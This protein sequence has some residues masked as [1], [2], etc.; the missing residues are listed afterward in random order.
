M[1]NSHDNSPET[2]R[3]TIT[4]ILML[5]LCAQQGHPAIIQQWTSI[6]R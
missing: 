4:D 6:H 2:H 3:K 5:P 1:H